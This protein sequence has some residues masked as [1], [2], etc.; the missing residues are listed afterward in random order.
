MKSDKSSQGARALAIFDSCDD[1][2]K[3][4]IEKLIEMREWSVALLSRFCGLVCY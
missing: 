1:S 3:Q 4:P 2:W